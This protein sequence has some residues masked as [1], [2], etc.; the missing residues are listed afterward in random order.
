MP[1]GLG[2]LDSRHQALHTVTH[3]GST[4]WTNDP[5]RRLVELAPGQTAQAGL[6]WPG[7]TPVAPR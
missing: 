7:R 5:G 4:W 3:W 1:P 2:L 6:A